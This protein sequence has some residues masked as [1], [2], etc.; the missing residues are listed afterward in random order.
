MARRWIRTRVQLCKAADREMLDLQTKETSMSTATHIIFV[1]KEGTNLG[2][3]PGSGIVAA[4]DDAAARTVVI[5]FEGNLYGASN[6]SD[7]ESRVNQAAGRQAQRYPTIARMVAPREDLIEVG[8]FDYSANQIVSL[9]NEHA[10]AKWIP[11]ETSWIGS[12][13]PPW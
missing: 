4:I 8:R 11:D 13:L 3:H 5:Y 10:L 1:P 12:F 6:L 9:L 7:F 2:I